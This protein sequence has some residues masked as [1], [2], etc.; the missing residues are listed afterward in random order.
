MKIHRHIESVVADPQTAESRIAALQTAI[1]QLEG[2]VF[3]WTKSLS[4]G[5]PQAKSIRHQ[6]AVNARWAR[7]REA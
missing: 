4:L 7:A 2:D 6:R 1:H 3:R 5:A